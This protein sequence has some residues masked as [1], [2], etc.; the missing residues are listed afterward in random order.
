MPKMKELRFA[1]AHEKRV[2]FFENRHPEYIKLFE[3]NLDISQYIRLF[4]V[5]IKYQP[6]TE[7]TMIPFTKYF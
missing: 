2:Q 1:D 3:E 4:I 6:F 5:A 7:P